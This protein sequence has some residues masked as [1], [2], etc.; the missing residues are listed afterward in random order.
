PAASAVA[1]AE[2]RMILR[3]VQGKIAMC[4]TPGV[5]LF[6]GV[7]WARRPGELEIHLP[8]P[9]GPL[10]GFAGILLAL[11]TL[12]PATLNQF[13]MDRA[14]LTLEFLSPVSDRDLIRGKAAAAAIL[15]GSRGLCC[16][17]IALVTAPGGSPFYWLAALAAGGA[18]FLLLASGGAIL[19]T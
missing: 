10:L 3:T 9:F 2:V 19:S 5:V 4:V 13:A 11:L 14:G 6:L 12:E 17:L 7:L 18:V 8:L 16:Y 1:V 15:G